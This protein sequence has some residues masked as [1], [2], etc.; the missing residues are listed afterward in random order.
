MKYL[1][2]PSLL[3]MAVSLVIFLSGCFSEVVKVR[4]PLPDII[5][6]KPP[7]DPRLRFVNSVSKPADLNIRMGKFNKLIRFIKGEKE[8]SIVHPYGITTDNEGRMYV[9]DTSNRFVHV[10]D[11]QRNEYYVFPEKDDSLISP[12]DIAVDTRGY[13]YVTDSKDAVVKIYKEHGRK[14]VKEIGTGL[15]ERPTGIALN[16]Q[17]GEILV[18][19]TKSSQVIRLDMQSHRFKG[20]IGDEGNIQGSFHSPTNIFVAGDGTIYISDALN[21]RI[22][23]FTPEGKF[24]SAFGKAGDG[25]GYLARPRGVAADSDGNIYVV[26]ALFDNVQVFDKKGRLLTAF[27]RAGYDYGEFWLPSGIFIDSNDRIYVSDSYNN[28][29]QI[30]QY[31]KVTDLTTP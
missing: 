28:R 6:P 16:K 15:F 9:V 7:A 25:P 26:D 13:I 11:A 29:V 14:Y 27:G 21:F 24:I 5:W 30:F 18:V 23:I 22:Q 8:T 12:I 1:K 3:L 10:F 31:M 2:Y 20:N 17:T 19:D 4:E